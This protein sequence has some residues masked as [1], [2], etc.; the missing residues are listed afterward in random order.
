MLFP[1]DIFLIIAIIEKQIFH[2][3]KYKGVFLILFT[4]QMKFLTI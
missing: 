1:L 4:H 2:K 3:N